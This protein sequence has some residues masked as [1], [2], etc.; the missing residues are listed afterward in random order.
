M[1]TYAWKHPE[2][3]TLVRVQQLAD[4][5]PAPGEPYVLISPAELKQWEQAELAGGW[6]P[7]Q[8]APA[9]ERWRVSKDTLI[10][11]VV[12]ADRLPDVM[13]AL[14]AQPAADPFIWYQSAWFW[15]DN[16]RIRGLCTA[17]G[18]DAEALLA[19]DPYLE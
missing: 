18:L 1:K 2:P 19:A 13:A 5:A 4:D 16:P 7:V 14:A 17:L 11:R 8:I 9:I 15:S 10:S 6:T 3:D 12:A